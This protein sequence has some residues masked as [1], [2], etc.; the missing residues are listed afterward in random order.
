VATG[1]KRGGIRRRNWLHPTRHHK[2][3]DSAS[4]PDPSEGSELHRAEQREG[5][6]HQE[7]DAQTSLDQVLRHAA[8]AR[9]RHD[10]DEDGEPD[11]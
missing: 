6:R 2:Q 4:P 3:G 1:R 11:A 8:E 5:V 7:Q 10:E 9:D